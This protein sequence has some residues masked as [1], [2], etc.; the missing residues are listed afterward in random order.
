TLEDEEGLEP[1]LELID[2]APATAAAAPSMAAASDSDKRIA[3]LLDEGQEAYDRG[4]H[5]AAIDAWSRIF[6]IDIDHAEAARRIE[7]ARKLKAG[8]ERQVEEIF[9]EGAAHLEAGE[10]DPARAAFR[11]VLELQPGHLAA[12]EMLQRADAPP[13]PAKRAP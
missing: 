11:K 8:S 1:S 12:R 4:E 5:Q 7:Q 13:Q 10:L 3:E 2:E 9:H 6:L